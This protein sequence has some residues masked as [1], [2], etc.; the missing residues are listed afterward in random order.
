MNAKD[1]EKQFVDKISGLLNDGV[2]NLDSQT[3]RQLE[4]IRVSALRAAE[5]HLRLFIPV[6]WIMFGGLA[7]AATAAV[8]LFFWLNTNSPGD[9]PLRDIEDLEIITSQERVDFYE[10]LDF[11]RWLDTKGNSG[12]HEKVS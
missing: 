11:Y 6:R 1:V 3:E 5:T 4:H 2:E 8:A 9:F 10:N 12:V 7:T